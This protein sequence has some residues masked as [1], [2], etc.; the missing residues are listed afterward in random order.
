MDVGWRRW[1][2]YQACSLMGRHMKRLSL[3]LKRS[4]CVCSQINLNMGKVLV[5]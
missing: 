1:S 4:L 5:R 2:N 3:K